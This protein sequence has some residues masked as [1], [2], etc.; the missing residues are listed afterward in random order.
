MII[1]TISLTNI[2]T[3]IDALYYV[4]PDTRSNT[5]GIVSMG[6]GSLK[7]NSSV[8][9]L[10]AKISTEVEIVG[11]YKHLP[12]NICMMNFMTAQGYKIKDNIIYQDNQS[13]IRM[14]NNRG[15]S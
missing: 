2:F 15:T 11:V 13:G 4:Y 10:N 8:Q 14:E 12:Y 7:S 9:K 5:A 3:W 1:G 6:I